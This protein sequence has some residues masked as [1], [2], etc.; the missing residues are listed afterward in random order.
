[1]NKQ[2]KYI[3]SGLFYLTLFKIA[4]AYNGMDSVIILGLTFIITNQ[5]HTNKDEQS[6]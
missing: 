3:L 2:F 4:N 6:R 1:M 5:L